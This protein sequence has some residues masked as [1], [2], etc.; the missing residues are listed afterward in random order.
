MEHL[1]RILFMVTEHVKDATVA[2]SKGIITATRW[3][4]PARAEFMQHLDARAN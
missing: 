3:Q 2:L 1:I 4:I